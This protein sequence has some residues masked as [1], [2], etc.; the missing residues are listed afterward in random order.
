MTRTQFE[1]L[2]TSIAGSLT[3]EMRH[4]PFKESKGFENRVR[5]LVQDRLGSHIKID[6]SPSPQAFPDIVVG[7][8]GVEVKFTDKDTWRSVANSV[9]ESTRSEA[10]EEVYVMFGKQGGTPEA[11]WGKYGDCVMHVRTSHVP[12]FEVEIGTPR[13]LFDLMGLTYDDFRKL[14]LADKMKHIRK[15]ARG[16]LK[17]GERLW[18]LEDSPE[19]EHALPLE[20]RLYMRL[21]QAEKRR[22]R[23][24]AALLCPQIV[25]GSRVRDKYNDAVSYLM[26]Y[27][28]VL[29]PQARDL[30]SAGSVALRAN[31]KRGG[32]Y[33]QRALEDIQDEMRMAAKEL[34]NALFVEYWGESVEPGQRLKRWLVKADGFARGWK[35][36][37][38]LFKE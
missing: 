31:A 25:G 9:F 23:A 5:E 19:G 34:E 26:T 29:C 10:V 12:R 36:S 21:P 22:L 32:I 11:R 1:E 38:V 30:F 7:K 8:C 17:P 24:E 37:A 16:R 18:W 20:V 14:A 28:G 2:L 4:D 35:P 3:E 27:R 6:F 15:Y 13:S 33:I